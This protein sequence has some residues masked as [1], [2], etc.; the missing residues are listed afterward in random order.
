MLNRFICIKHCNS[1]R[2]SELLSS[3]FSTYVLRGAIDDYL[4]PENEL[5]IMK[6][7]I[8]L[9]MTIISIENES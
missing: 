1:L 5:L 6:S 8:I 4:Y 3:V 9:I 2:L 7:L